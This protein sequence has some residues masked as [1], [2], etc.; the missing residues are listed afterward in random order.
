MNIQS[1]ID[2]IAEAFSL[3]DFSYFISGTTSLSVL[4][5]FM[6]YNG[7][8][9]KISLYIWILVPLLLVSV[10]VSGIVSMACGKWLRL[11]ILSC[12]QYRN[13]FGINNF[14]ECYTQAI[15]ETKLDV[16]KLAED[17][18]ISYTMMW[19][20]LKTATEY[21]STVNFINK[22][23]V[24]QA[25]CEGLMTTCLLAIAAVWITYFYSHCVNSF[26][27][28]FVTVLALGSFVIFMRY[29]RQNAEIQIKEVVA[30]Y[31]LM[32]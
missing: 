1:I 9:P 12:K 11:T 16:N 31:S 7:I 2:R 28:L 26:T 29:A 3:F 25:L 24:T 30:A 13:L 17:S 5:T 14:K 8:F 20:A 19:T 10:Y 4:L 27:G 22:Y 6:W 15:K 18:N 23:W 21:A 32:K